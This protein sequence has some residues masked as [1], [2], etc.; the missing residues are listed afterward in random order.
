MRAGLILALLLSGLLL[1]AALYR[2]ATAPGAPA[3]TKHTR[4]GSTVEA[5]RGA[6]PAPAAGAFWE[7]LAEE[8]AAR[9]RLEAE[10]AAM[11]LE[12]DFLRTGELGGVAARSGTMPTPD[13][14]GATPRGAEAGASEGAAGSNTG[15]DRKDAGLRV[16][17]ESILLDEAGMPA[18]EVERLRAAF[19]EVEL[20]Q[21]YLRDRARRERWGFRRLQLEGA[22]LTSRTQTLR[23]EF[24]DASY[25]WYLYARGAENRVYVGDVLAQSPAADAGFETGDRVLRYDGAAVFDRRD[26]DRL[27]AAGELGESVRVEVDRGGDTVTLEIPRGSLGARVGSRSERPA[28]RP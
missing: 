23:E 7:A 10:I 15:R 6:P 28:Q 4:D 17:D 11:R 13:A 1:G 25:D 14:D 18:S 2:A 16:F 24:G 26:L 19:Q 21:L 22:E 5:E 27:S 9:L 20:E 8:R 12:L 3:G